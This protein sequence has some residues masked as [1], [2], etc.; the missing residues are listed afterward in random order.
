MANLIAAWA[1]HDLHHIA[2][3]C[4]GLARQNRD[5]VGPWGPHMGILVRG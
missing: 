2:Q 5:Q 1:T 3:V 4:K